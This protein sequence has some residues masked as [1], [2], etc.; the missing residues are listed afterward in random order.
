MNL[1]FK[2]AISCYSLTHS[3][4]I[5][6]ASLTN[7]CLQAAIDATS[8][9][10]EK[11]KVDLLLSNYSLTHSFAYSLT[12]SRIVSYTFP[13]LQLLALDAFFK[14][15]REGNISDVKKRLDDGLHA[16]SQNEKGN[17]ALMEASEYGHEAVCELLITRGCNV[18]MQDK[19]GDTA[20]MEASLYGYIP[21]VISL[22]EAGCDYSLR[23]KEGKSAMDYL[24]E[25][26]PGKVKEVQVSRSPT[27]V[28]T[29]S[30]I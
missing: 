9:K 27:A 8:E 23:N 10:K 4:T 15:A 29:H 20:L 12:H 21:V 3:V 25:R 17:T 16:D 18:D 19:N 14:S 5:T 24:R 7:Q 6:L 13:F 1:D 26:H 30:L 22:I 2:Q 11:E 28:V